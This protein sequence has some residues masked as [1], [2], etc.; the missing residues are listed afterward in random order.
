MSCHK[1]PNS[2]LTPT[3]ATANS[4]VSEKI[5][6]THSNKEWPGGSS[7]AVEAAFEVRCIQ[8]HNPHGSSNLFD[9]RPDVRLQQS[10]AVVTSGPVVFTTLTGTAP[11]YTDS[12]DEVDPVENAANNA[13]DLCV[14]CH[15]NPSNTPGMTN[16]NGGLHLA[17]ADYRGLDCTTCHPHS[18]DSSATTKDGFMTGCRA[19]HNKPQ[20]NGD[21][22]PV[23]GRRQIVG[24]TGGDFTRSSHH[25]N[26]ADTVTDADCQICHEM[27]QHKAGTVRLRN[28]D[29]GTAYTLNYTTLRT[30]PTQA[31]SDAYETFCISCHDSNGRAGDTTPFSDQKLVPAVSNL[32]SSISPVPA[33]HNGTFTPFLGSCLDCHDSGHGSNK[34]KLLDPWNYTG[35]GTTIRK[36]S[37]V[38]AATPP[39]LAVR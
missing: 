25:V 26:G 4:P 1:D 8:C 28:V 35:D 15:I 13:D 3:C 38:I 2:T 23:G 17:G 10:P 29:T 32:W 11:S 39:R 19:C 16:H 6:S 33:R 34:L 30:T 24:A 14:T 31:D 7:S 9:I 12:F 27:S 5:V 18:L 20:D 36:R 37:S 22:K 21:N